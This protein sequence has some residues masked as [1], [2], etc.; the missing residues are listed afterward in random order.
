MSEI[1]RTDTSADGWSEVLGQDRAVAQLQASVA[2]PVHAYLFVGPPGSGRRAAARAFAADL[3]AVGSDGQDAT[4]HRHLALAEQHPDLT[5]FVPEGASLRDEEAAEIIK[6]SVRSPVEGRRKVLVLTEFHKISVV[7]PKLLKIVEEPP[8]S[9][10]F[11]ILADDV[12]P[13]LV[14]IA[15]RAVRIDFHPVPEALVIE[16]LVAE[17][18]EAAAAADA[19]AAA[20]GDLDRA[21][22]LATDPELA[23]R[24]AAWHAVPDRV[25]GTGAAVMVVT[26]ELIALIDRAQAPLAERHA[27]EAA[28][29][30]ERVERYGQR[31]SGATQLTAQHRREAR[32]AR[33]AELRFGFATLARRYRDG[34]VDA[35]RPEELLLKL[36]A[37]QAASE[38]L[39]RNPNEALLLEDLL[40]TL[41]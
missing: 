17:G 34:L 13:E 1:V 36:A 15:S 25:D 40:F 5:V 4:R 3:L 2:A 16:R 39:I 30:A 21:R 7:A 20:G 28:E 41:A 10:V 8:P 33:V 29:L 22:L 19:A 32:R 38:A 37:I 23:D 14:T 26:A 24:Q 9:T 35:R 11:V 18:V 6:A 31:G 12:P 27:I